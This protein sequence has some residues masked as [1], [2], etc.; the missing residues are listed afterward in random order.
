VPGRIIVFGATGYTGRLTAEALIARGERPVLAGRNAQRLTE[1]SGELGGELDT[2]V[3]DVARPETVAD[4]VEG[5]DVLVSTVGPFGRWG[6]PAVE[7]AISNQAAYLDSTGEPGFIRA[8]FE[9]YGPRAEAAGTGLVTAFGYDWV[10]GN[11]AGALALEEAGDPAVR[12]DVGYFFTGSA[13]MSGGTR[14][15]TALGAVEPSF[16]WRR[17]IKTERIAARVRQFNVNGR[18]RPAVSA[19]SSEHFALPR[20]YPRLEE[21]NAYL[22]WFGGASRPMQA[23]SLVGTGVA[24]LPGA[25]SGMRALAGRF[26]KGS[27]GGPD[28]EQR[29]RSG[30]HIV[31]VA[32]DRAGQELAEV[33]VAGVNGYEFTG[34]IL[35]WGATQALADG[36]RGQGALGPVEAFG[37]SELEA[38]CAEAGIARVAPS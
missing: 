16:V 29:S 4:L 1:L 31:A 34:R 5:G 19:G 22:G 13:G 9:R 3:A 23:F 17:G 14:A 32:Y 18:S 36:L 21:V 2:A 35:A 7:A 37:L 38:G 11:L 8:V 26:V 20:L 12:V 25:R 30:S 6:E 24:K 15:T 27:T 10:P 28:A 33:R